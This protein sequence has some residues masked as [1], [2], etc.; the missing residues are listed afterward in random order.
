MT[1]PRGEQLWTRYHN[2]SGNL[3][4]ITTSKPV[5][6]F[7]FLYE[8]VDGSFHKLGKAKSPLELEAKFK[9]V[10]KLNSITP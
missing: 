2:I 5:R 3:V 8:L 1:Y 10:E 9:V 7:Y 6:D 4:F